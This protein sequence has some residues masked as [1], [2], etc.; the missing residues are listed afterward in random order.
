MNPDFYQLYQNLPVPEL[1][2]VAK[3]PSDYMPEAVSAA[4]RILKERGI[5]KEE[6]AAE[7]WAIAQEEMQAGIK[8]HSRRDFAASIGELFGRDLQAN[9]SETWLMV[10]ILLYGIYYLYNIFVVISQLAWLY[11]HGSPSYGRSLL[12]SDLVFACYITLCL[13]YIL[14]QLWLGWSLLL[15]HVAYILGMKFS[16]LF[17]LYA[18]HELFF[19]R[20]CMLTF[21]TLI[22]VVFGALLWRPFVITTFKI[23]AKIKSRTLLV[24]AFAGIVGMI[25]A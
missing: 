17:H 21:P 18:H 8:K 19:E 3:T 24:A 5:A 13:Y 6:I 15:I 11:K 4:E 14:R 7:E 16:I 9:P 25:I 2:K 20:A 1:V 22:Y 12:V 23:D 10:F